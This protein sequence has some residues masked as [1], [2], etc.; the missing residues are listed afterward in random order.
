MSRQVQLGLLVAAVVLGGCTAASSGG[1]PT[2]SQYPGAA[3]S[4][5]VG[6]TLAPKASSG[7]ALPI[8]PAEPSDSG[9]QVGSRGGPVYPPILATGERLDSVGS[10]ESRGLEVIEPKGLPAGLPLQ[11]VLFDEAT[12]A[13]GDVAMGKQSVRLYYGNDSLEVGTT[14]VDLYRDGGIYLS[15]SETSGQDA[16]MVVETIGDAAQVIQV[17]PNEAALVHSSPFPGGFRTWNLYW[18]DGKLDYALSGDASP[19]DL[20]TFAQAMFC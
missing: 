8:L 14:I 12:P 13:D 15:E 9:D 18:S 1:N 3:S 19:E 20:I 6:A 16:N 11:A 5:D 4:T 7:C 2:V 17:G 10:A